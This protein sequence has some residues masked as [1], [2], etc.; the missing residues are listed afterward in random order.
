MP[1][2]G[3]AALLRFGCVLGVCG[4]YFLPQKNPPGGA[5]GDA[6][7]SGS[8]QAEIKGLAAFLSFSVF[9][10]AAFKVPFREQIF[11]YLGAGR[12]NF[13]IRSSVSV[14]PSAAPRILWSAVGLKA[15]V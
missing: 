7:K 15:D 9:G 6:A 2:R 4:A 13:R 3:S 1:K 14:P 8:F 11:L 10:S 12:L 5:E